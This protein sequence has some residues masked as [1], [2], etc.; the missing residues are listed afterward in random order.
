MCDFPGIGLGTVQFGLPYGISNTIGRTTPSDVHRILNYAEEHDIRILDTASAYGDAEKVLGNCLPERHGF[1]I[2]TKIP[3]YSE[4]IVDAAEIKRRVRSSLGFL[5]QQSVY[6]ILFH[7]AGDLLSA[8]GEFLWDALVQ[9]KEKGWTEKIGV[10][11]YSPDEA[12]RIIE[13]YRLDILQIP[14][15]IFDQRFL[16]RGHLIDIN[17]KGIEIHARSC[18]LQGLLLM[19]PQNLSSFF[20]PAKNRLEHFRKICDQ[21]GY[22][23]LEAALSFVLSVK[24]LHTVIVGVNSLLHLQEIICSLKKNSYKADEIFNFGCFALDMPDIVEPRL[25]P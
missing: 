14:V 13:R 6:G 11:V 9:I 20:D 21:H 10:S 25:W 24:E 7:D 19:K 16:N 2:V 3:S 1:R 4:K 17:N 5:K 8:R 23:P 18:F 22:T 15:N 12:E